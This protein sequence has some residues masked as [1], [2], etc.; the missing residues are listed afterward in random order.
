VIFSNLNGCV[1]LRRSSY[2]AISQQGLRPGVAFVRVFASSALCTKLGS[3]L[4][5]HC[6]YLW[7]KE[8]V[9]GLFLHF[10]FSE[11]S[12][13]MPAFTLVKDLTESVHV[14]ICL[15]VRM[16]F[17]YLVNLRLG[18]SNPKY[19]HISE[20]V[21][22]PAPFWASFKLL[23]TFA[24][25]N[26]PFCADT[27]SVLRAAAEAPT[28]PAL[29]GTRS[30]ESSIW[31]GSWA[32]SEMSAAPLFFLNPCRRISALHVF[33]QFLSAV[34]FRCFICRAKTKYHSK[35][36]SPL[37]QIHIGK[38]TGG[39]EQKPF[40]CQG[41]LTSCRNSIKI[42]DWRSIRAVL[43]PLSSVLCF[44]WWLPAARKTNL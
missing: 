10:S 23:R 13:P 27:V 34:L 4:S 20:L 5:L 2:C 42:T 24:S 30:G 36:K 6:D 12:E 41:Y 22:G 14:F 38:T 28:A 40:C 1:I 15:N 26:F 19:F 11:T 9:H 43:H 18:H 31:S 21:S 33:I 37:H 8:E 29:P 17:K 39:G 44:R 25:E 32:V 35:K 16:C 3:T 7:P